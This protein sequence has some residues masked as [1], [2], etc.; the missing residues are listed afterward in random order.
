M[1]VK[2]KHN[3]KRNVA[4]LYE[5]LVR[6]ITKSVIEN[7]DKKKEVVIS[8]L[9]ESFS[10][11][12]LLYK[13]LRLYKSLY[14]TDNLDLSSA[15]R[16]IHE[17]RNQYNNLDK[18]QLFLEQSNLIKKIN[19]DIS[20]SVYSNFVPNYKNLATI[21][22]I[23][24]LEDGSPKDKILLENTLI[25]KLVVESK[26]VQK[27]MVPHTNLVLKSFI[28]NFN[29]EYSSKLLEEQKNLLN[30]YVLSFVD[31]GIELKIFLNEEVGRLNKAISSSLK[32]DEIK[33]DEEMFRKTK[34]VL[35]I[36]ENF[37]NERFNKKSL[38]NILKIQNLVKEIAA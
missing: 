17:A 25:N 30:K 19:K 26:E 7:E 9:K 36:L 12:S 2:L 33:N 31:N 24:N 35:Q 28:K 37:K 8:I 27:K 34:E 20:K 29:E 10:K 11:F 3:K 23:F 32:L 4:F 13:E 16:L 22:Q 38:S 18:E 14:E 15:E 1:K 21:Y 5:C 6:E